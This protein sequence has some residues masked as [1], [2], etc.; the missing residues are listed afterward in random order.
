MLR[1]TS[2]LSSMWAPLLRELLFYL[3]GQEG[4]LQKNSKPIHDQS[5]DA[6]VDGAKRALGKKRYNILYTVLHSMRKYF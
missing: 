1:P 4:P 3:N 2:L 5:S 6:S